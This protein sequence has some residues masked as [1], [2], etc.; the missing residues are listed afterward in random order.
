MKRERKPTP[1][2]SGDGSDPAVCVI[3][4]CPNEVPGTPVSIGEKLNSIVCKGGKLV[5]QNNNAGPDK[6][7]TD[8]H[9][10][11][12]IRDW[13]KRY[14]KD[15]CKGIPDGSLPVGGDGYVEFLRNTEY[16]A[17]EVGKKCRKALIKTADKKDHSTIN[18]AIDRD[19]AQLKANKCK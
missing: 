12:H 18:S 1:P 19:D 17:Y 14:G 15:L 2:S 3:A 16:K 11:S 7:C 13:E 4:E 9:E 6:K 5:V 8:A 10:K